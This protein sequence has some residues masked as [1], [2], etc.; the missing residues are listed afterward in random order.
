MSRKN[1][2]GAKI[3]TWTI[4]GEKFTNWKGIPRFWNHL[5]TQVDMRLCR[6]TGYY[7]ELH[8][9][10]LRKPRNMWNKH[11]YCHRVRLRSA[12]ILC[13]FNNCYLFNI[14]IKLFTLI[15]LHSK[16]V[17]KRVCGNVDCWVFDAQIVCRWNYFSTCTSL[18]VIIK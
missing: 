9:F 14:Q 17:Y 12:F 2:S 13:T 7:P 4:K 3:M 15:L 11:S 18:L 5:H 10:Y 16:S 6:W 8:V 1:K